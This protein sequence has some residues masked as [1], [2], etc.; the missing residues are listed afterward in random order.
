M[1]ELLTKTN[2]DRSLVTSYGVRSYKRILESTK[3]HL[4]DDTSGHINTIRGP[5][6]RDVISQLF[7]TGSGRVI[8]QRQLWTT[9]R[10]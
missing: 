1:W 9:F 3:G 4:C 6:F 5:K 7:P 2:V 10:Q 8:R